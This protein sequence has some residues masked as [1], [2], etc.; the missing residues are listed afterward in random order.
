MFRKIFKFLVGLLAFVGLIVILGLGSAFFTLKSRVTETVSVPDKAIVYIDLTENYP[1][2]HKTRFLVSGNSVSFR[3]LLG[4]IEKARSDPKVVAI[5]AKGGPGNLGMAQAEEVRKAI[6]SFEQAGKVALYYADDLGSGWN[7]S[8]EYYLATAFDKIVLHPSAGVGATGYAI[9]MPYLADTLDRFGVKPEFEQRYEFKGGADPYTQNGIT[10]PVKETMTAL[11]S[12]WRNALTRTMAERR[13]LSPEKAKGIIDSGPYSSEEALDL[14]L[15]DK[16]AYRDGFDRMVDELIDPEAMYIDLS[17][18]VAASRKTFNDR[19]RVAVVYGIGPIVSVA[20]GSFSGDET[21]DPERV[22]GSMEELI[23]DPDIQAVVFRIDSPGGEYGPSDSLW[24]TVSRLRAADKYVVVSMG[25]IAASGGYFAAAG[26]NRIFADAG[27]VTGSIGVYAG[28]FSTIDLWKKLGVNWAGLKAGENA[29]FWSFIEPMT[30]VQQARFSDLIDEA[31]DDFS[32]K[33]AMARGMSPSQIDKVARGRIWI[34]KDALSAG[35]VDSIGGLSDAVRVAAR[36]VGAEPP[37][38]LDVAVY[39]K[40]RTLADEIADMITSF[41]NEGLAGSLSNSFATV[42]NKVG[43]NLQS[44]IVQS[45]GPK[46]VL[47]PMKIEW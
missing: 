20:S 15:V 30:P 22:M 2:E 29:D 11:L 18:Y 31:Y 43:G 6:L 19:A 13:G 38:L 10:E 41:R 9:E 21:F 36:T 5:V 8:T 24:H 47:P 28:K 33:V 3:E 27:T 25:N 23:D 12:G 14:N 46:A 1:E 7:G 35:L 45:G 39:P 42:M 40:P 4:G 26:A 37:S 44:G 32:T 16:L 17:D 34:G